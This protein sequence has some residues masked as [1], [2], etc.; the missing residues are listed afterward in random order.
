KQRIYAQKHLDE[1]IQK[2]AQKE[3]EIRDFGELESLKEIRKV[4]ETKSSQKQ[5]RVPYRS[6]TIDGFEIRIGKGARDN[7]ELLRSFTSRHDLWLHAKSVSGS[8][9]IIYNPSK[10]DVPLN[11][12]EKIAQI[13]A[14]YSKAKSEGMAA[15][16]YTHRKYVRKPK[17]ATPGLV[18]VDKEDVIL[19]EPNINPA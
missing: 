9:V 15:V 19:V 1:V 8:H 6:T 14:F 4:S 16:I 10:K 17:G 2:V 11:T 12:I 13:A 18:K 3:E 7:D 5:T